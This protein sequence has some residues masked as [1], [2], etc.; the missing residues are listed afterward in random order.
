VDVDEVR[1]VCNGERRFI[2]PVRNASGLVDKFVQEIGF[3]LT[4]DA[5]ICVEAIGR[6]TLFPVL[7]SPSETGLFEDGTIPYAL[8]NPVWIDVDGNGRFDPPFPGKVLPTA[9]PGSP[10]KKVSRY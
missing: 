10:N 1:L 6:K 5:Y 2:F 8:T 9:D 3:N 7:Q 4:K